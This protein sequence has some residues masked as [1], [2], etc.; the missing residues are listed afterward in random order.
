VPFDG[1]GKGA[2]YGRTLLHKAAR[3]GNVDEVRR[4]LV[5]VP[6]IRASAVDNDGST[7]LHDAVLCGDDVKAAAVS[8]HLCPG[9]FPHAPHKF[10]SKCSTENLG[11]IDLSEA[12]LFHYVYLLRHSAMIVT[13]E[14]YVNHCLKV[15]GLG[16]K[17]IKKAFDDRPLPDPLGALSA[18]PRTPIAGLR[19]L[20]KIQE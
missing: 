4:L 7:A 9:A 17:H 18:L 16:I 8:R 10:W 12:N 6:T 2:T 14:N 1:K 20:G 11:E 13:A 5:S 19:K 15:F 3:K